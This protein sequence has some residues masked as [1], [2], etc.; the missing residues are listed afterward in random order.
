MTRGHAAGVRYK[1]IVFYSEDTHYSVIK[2]VRMLDLT[3]FQEEALEQGEEKLPCPEGFKAWPEQVPS[4]EGTIDVKAL[5]ALVEPFIALD[6]PIILVLNLGS[7]WKGAYD[8]VDEVRDMLVGFKTDYPWLWKR[9]V[10]WKDEESDWRRGFWLHVDGALGAS[11]LPFLEMAQREH[12]WKP[13]K[14]LP[15]FDFRNEAVMSICTSTHKW[16][17]GPWG[18]SVYMT[19]TKYQLSPPSNPSY[20]GAADT[21]LGGSRN[22]VTA[23][24]VWD[25]LARTS[26]EDSMMAAIEAEAT[27]EFLE[28]E[29]LGL[30][31]RLKE[32]YPE[33]AWCFME[34]DIK[35]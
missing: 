6:Y 29:L 2:C 15:Q 23:A 8:P 33:I 1:P 5:K 19:K 27:A 16:P 30:E 31:A 17:G 10:K 20:I 28:Q 12:G 35:D 3:G 22:A 18:G 14:H 4:P 11:Y 34:P 32:A 24:L 9:E 7:T 13:E 26:Y 25:Y 21:T